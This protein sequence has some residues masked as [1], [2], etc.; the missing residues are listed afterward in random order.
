[1]PPDFFVFST[2]VEAEERFFVLL[3]GSIPRAMPPPSSAEEMM[4]MWQR[5][6]RLPP[7][8]TEQEMRQQLMEIG[9]PAEDIERHIQRARHIRRTWTL[10]I[11]ER[12]T[13][14]GYRNAD[15]QVV[16]RKTDLAGTLPNQRVYVMRC[17]QCGHEYGTN[18]C[19]IHRCQCPNCQ[20]WL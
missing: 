6:L 2:E 13:T 11:I 4:R 17:D 15:G 10:P 8:L 5:D 3:P 12:T 19:D 1:M 9:V 14:I 18:G 20:D 16:T 7:L